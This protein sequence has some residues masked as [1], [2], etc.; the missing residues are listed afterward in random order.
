MSGEKW[1]P[2]IEVTEALAKTSI[3]EQFGKLLQV[4]DIKHIGSGWDNKVFLVNHDI[5][6][7]FP[8]R[9]LA[10]GLIER[11]NAILK[12]LHT[13]VC[14]E[15]PALEYIGQP[16]TYYPYYFHGYRKIKGI[17]GCYAGLAPT[18][19]IASLRPLATFLKELHSI[20][21]AKAEKIGG[22]HQIFDRTKINDVIETMSEQ[23]DKLIARGICKINKKC[24]EDEIALAKEIELPSDNKVLIHGDLYC[25]HLMFNQGK[26]A[27]V[28]DWGEVGI[29]NR[30][31]DLAV[32][33]SFYPSGCHKDFLEIYG[34]VEPNTWK[35]ARFLGLYDA[36]TIMLY[37]ADIDDKLLVKEATDSVR[38]IN[39][40]LLSRCSSA[41]A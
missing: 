17:S 27:G 2:D 29:N 31:V 16:S 20:T 11:E 9:K 19:R 23:V 38:R 21:E 33:F 13:R 7:R 5:I 39:A 37:G 28:I 4:E 35:C 30:A 12:N 34:E 6:F 15:I 14:V 32:I 24:F 40:D 3:E 8:H 18:E 22:R 36:L 1:H 25:R 26:L 10:A 41:L